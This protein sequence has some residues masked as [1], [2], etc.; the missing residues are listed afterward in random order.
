MVKYSTNLILAGIYSSLK[1]TRILCKIFGISQQ[2]TLPVFTTIPPTFS[3]LRLV[4]SIETFVATEIPQKFLN[5]LTYEGS[6]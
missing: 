5:I 6:K 3:S 4:F 2:I 1:E